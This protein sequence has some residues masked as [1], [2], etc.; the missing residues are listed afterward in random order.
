MVD[1]IEQS[2]DAARQRL[3]LRQWAGRLAIC[4]TAAFCVA[5][6]AILAPKVFVLPDLPASWALLWL[7]GSAIVGVVAYC[8]ITTIFGSMSGIRGR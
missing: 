3:V 8:M 1:E 2:V 5:L 7:A 4:L 6:V